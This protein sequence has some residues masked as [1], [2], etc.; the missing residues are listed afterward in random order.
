MSYEV[1]LQWENEADVKEP[2]QERL[3]YVFGWRLLVMPI[4][5]SKKTKGGLYLPDDVVQTAALVSRIGKVL[6]VGDGIFARE[7]LA[8]NSRKPQIGEYVEWR[9]NTGVP[10]QVDGVR[11]LYLTDID[12]LS[13]RDHLDSYDNAYTGS[14]S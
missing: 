12:L 1:T 8:L 2:A 3:P 10:T 5:P 14:P 9:V 6:A 13:I 4:T 7:D 11:L